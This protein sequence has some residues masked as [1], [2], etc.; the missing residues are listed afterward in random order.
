MLNFATDGVDSTANEPALS[1]ARRDG[2][3]PSRG[4]SLTCALERESG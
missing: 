4:R 3:D 2:G 1:T